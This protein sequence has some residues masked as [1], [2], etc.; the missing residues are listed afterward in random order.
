MNRWPQQLLEVQLVLEKAQKYMF[1][2]PHPVGFG[3]GVWIFLKKHPTTK[4]TVQNNVT[5]CNHNNNNNKNACG[6]SSPKP[7]FLGCW[8]F[9]AQCFFLLRSLKLLLIIVQTM[10]WS[11]EYKK[12]SK[13][14]HPP[15]GSNDVWKSKETEGLWLPRP[16][17][18]GCSGIIML[19]HRFHG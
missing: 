8:S 10:F 17:L 15:I 5:Y 11:L 6:V 12:G 3:F 7:K 4:T 13:L 1:H 18:C 16:I 9:L 14:T 2:K 19:L